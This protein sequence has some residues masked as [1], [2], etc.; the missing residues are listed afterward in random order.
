MQDLGEIDL[1][2][3]SP[4]HVSLGGGKDLVFT[5]TAL[6]DGSIQLDLDVEAKSADV[7]IPAFPH[8]RFA[9]HSGE[10]YE[11]FLGDRMVGF[12]PKLVTR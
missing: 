8:P 9:V 1:A 7:T 4:K 6:P 10:K 12:T 11:V 2:A 3:Q 5:K